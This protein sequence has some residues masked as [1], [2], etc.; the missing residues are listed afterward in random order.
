MSAGARQ[1]VMS[2]IFGDNRMRLL[3]LIVLILGSIVSKVAVADAV[4]PFERCTGIWAASAKTP[5]LSPDFNPTNIPAPNAK[6]S[7]NATREGLSLVGTR[8]NPSHLEI[9]LNPPLVEVLWSPDSR[10][11]VINVSDGGLVGSWEAKFYAIDAD[12]RPVSLDIQNII[13]PIANKLLKCEPKEEANIGA[14]SWLNDGEEV[15]IIA[16]VPPHSSCQNMGAVFGFRV[17]IKSGKIL[18]RISEDDLHKKW[19]NVLGCRFKKIP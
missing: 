9:L 17:S 4:C 7:I 10:N 5:Y 6:Y 16:E 14:V 8:S 19:P 12:G 11:F 15:L 2:E 1:L 3:V 18:E 13:M